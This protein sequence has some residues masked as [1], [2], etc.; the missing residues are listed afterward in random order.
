[1]KRFAIAFVVLA[2]LALA[3]SAP[4]I[5]FNQKSVMPE[6][7]APDFTM[8]QVLAC[9]NGN[10]Q[11]A[12]FQSDVGRYGNLF[13]LGNGARLSHLEF[14][15][16]GFGFPGPYNYDLE[17]WDP[18]SCTLVLAVN[19]L[20][21][22]DAANDIM[23]ESVDLCP[24]NLTAAGN[25]IVAID[26]NSCATPSDCYPDVLYDPQLNVFC[27]VIVDAST[28]QCF[29]VSAD[30]GPFLLRLEIDNCAVPTVPKTWGAV[31]N[32]YR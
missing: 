1:M 18:T 31:K 26:A 9:D 25:V 21:A 7:T 14:A 10:P 20:V 6:T 3:S 22:Q 29:D 11:S 5:D 27:P 8:A 12:Y 32:I 2:S 23:V 15:H 30:S 17:L 28:G 19:G 16:F 4:A 24:R 13:N